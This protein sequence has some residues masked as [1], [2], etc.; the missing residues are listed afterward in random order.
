MDNRRKL[1]VIAVTRDFSYF[2]YMELCT[3]K[4]KTGNMKQER[5]PYKLLIHCSIN[6]IRE[7]FEANINKIRLP[8]ETRYENLLQE[9]IISKLKYK[10]HLI[11][12]LQYECDSDYLLP[13]K[14]K[15]FARHYPVLVISPSMPES[16]YYFLR[17]LGID[18][19]VQLPADDD[20]ICDAITTILN[21]ETHGKP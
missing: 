21:E 7:G 12:I 20:A 11:V 3:N 1:N 8:I 14:I 9:G 2:S 18:H 19:I 10:P 17:T 4:T 6:Q 15:L 16:Y 5:P 13:L